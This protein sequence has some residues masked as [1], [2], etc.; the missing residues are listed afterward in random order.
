MFTLPYDFLQEV[1]QAFKY[2][3]SE[4]EGK[5]PYEQLKIY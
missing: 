5:I 1:E 2:F 4:R 3:E